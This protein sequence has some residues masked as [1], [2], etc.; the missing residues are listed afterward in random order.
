MMGI[1]CR[2]MTMEAFAAELKGT[3]GGGYV[4]KPVVDSTGLKGSW[5]FDI[6]FTYNFLAQ[7]AGSDA[8]TLFDAIDKQLGLKLEEQK[9]PTKVI[10]VDRVNEKPSANPPDTAQ[11]L[12]PLPPAATVP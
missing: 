6:K 3:A 10:I 1:S 2:N 8:V 9:L 4:T 12:P 7:I 11:K 5:D